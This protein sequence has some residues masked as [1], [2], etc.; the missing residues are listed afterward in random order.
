MVTVPFALY[1]CAM[2][3]SKKMSSGNA[4][5][6]FV[7][8]CD[9]DNNY[10]TCIQTA[11]ILYSVPIYKRATQYYGINGAVDIKKAS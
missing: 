5:T 4:D 7:S 8:N 6:T 1:V 2:A 11:G 10:V 9:H 3:S